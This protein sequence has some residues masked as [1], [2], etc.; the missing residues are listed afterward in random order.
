MNTTRYGR[1]DS[2]QVEAQLVEAL[3]DAA[4]STR[5][6]AALRDLKIAEETLV[7]YTSDNGP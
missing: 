3:S 5:L 7:W 2:A 6:R 4:P 1:T